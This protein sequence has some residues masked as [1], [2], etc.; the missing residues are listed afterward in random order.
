[1]IIGLDVSTSVVGIS[2][3]SDNSDLLCVDYI[4]LKKYENLYEKLKAFK[5]FYKNLR[6]KV[7]DN[8]PASS[9]QSLKL[10]IEEP[11][12]MFKANASMA[13]TLAKLQRYNGMISA[14]LYFEENIEPILINASHARNLCG[15]KIRRGEDAKKQVLTYVKDSG[16]FPEERWEYKKTG[17][18]KDYMYD[19]CDSWVVARAGYQTLRMENLNEEEG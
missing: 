15:L 8:T 6:E 18:V 10:Y 11:L 9:K 12:M 17:N 19:M 5:Q 3:L 2:F 14:F 16:I 13:S 7:V 1:M 4:D